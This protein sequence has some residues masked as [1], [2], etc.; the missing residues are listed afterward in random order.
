MMPFGGSAERKRARQDRMKRL[1]ES[2]QRFK[3]QPQTDDPS[4]ALL[5]S[6][7]LAVWI[8]CWIMMIDVAFNFLLLLDMP[9]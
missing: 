8:I 2:N 6:I 4:E 9:R 3:P 7:R 5:I 1:Y